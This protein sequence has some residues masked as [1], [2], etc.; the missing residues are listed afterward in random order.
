VSATSTP[1][2]V[3][4]SGAS[5]APISVAVVNRTGPR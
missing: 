2:N 3:S 4:I 1:T 5:A